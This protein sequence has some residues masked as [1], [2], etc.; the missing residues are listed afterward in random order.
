MTVIDGRITPTE[1]VHGS[2]PVRT[3]GEDRLALISLNDC[4]QPTK[5][6]IVR[7]SDKSS[8]CDGR[9]AKTRSVIIFILCRP[10][11]CQCEVAWTTVRLG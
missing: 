6:T 9:M 8:L 2:R 1:L 5:E 10:H 11:E 7:S 3:Y 4:K